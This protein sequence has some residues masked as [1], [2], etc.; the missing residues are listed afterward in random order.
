MKVSILC[1]VYNHE[2]YLKK[3]LDGFI[4]Q[5]C[6]FEY[7]VLIHDDASTDKSAEIIR[8]YE[9]KYPNIIKPIYQTENQ[10]SKGVKISSIFQYPRAKGEYLAWCEGDD[11][12][13]DEN[14]LQK[15]VDF[16]DAHPEYIACV[17]RY[18]T[19]NKIGEKTDIRCFGQYEQKGVYTLDDFQHYDLPSQI[20]TLVAR[21][22]LTDNMKY[23]QAFN[24]VNATGDVK[25]F[26]FLLLNG[27]IWRMDEVFSV[28][29][30]VSEQNS[31]SWTSSL[32]KKKSVYHKQW[33]GIRQLEK[34]V[35]KEFGIHFKCDKRKQ[36]LAY[37]D[38]LI[39][40]K[41]PFRIIFKCIYY[42]FKQRGM[43]AVLAGKLLKGQRGAI[44]TNKE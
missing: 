29:R 38:I 13:T 43:L 2:P 18:D 30:I 20:A 5:K 41:N 32:L 6:N 23:T 21:N 35:K 27:N 11:Y 8:E 15:Q 10:Y 9:E 4:N 3:C 12:W 24:N 7:E 14:K 37:F 19:I 25:L 44:L 39:R 26:L 17:H 33:K 40:K 16:L 34:A 22:I 28:Y 1:L 36:Q 31:D 42:T